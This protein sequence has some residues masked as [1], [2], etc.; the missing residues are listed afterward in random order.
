M[1]DRKLEKECA[2]AQQE[3]SNTSEL[4]VRC[5]E[6]NTR[7]AGVLLHSRMTGAFRRAAA[8]ELT[9]RHTRKLRATCAAAQ[10]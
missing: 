1:V 6:C 3:H 5:E 10:P 4:H 2:L 7:R 9:P 8:H